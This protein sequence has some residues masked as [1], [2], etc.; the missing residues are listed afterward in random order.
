MTSGD[1]G[2]S[3]ASELCDQRDEQASLRRIANSMPKEKWYHYTDVHGLR[4]IIDRAELWGTHTAFLNDS[5]ELAYGVEVLAQLVNR[6]ASEMNLF[7]QGENGTRRMHPMVS[8]WQSMDASIKG[9]KDQLAYDLAPFVSCLSRSRDQLSQWRGYGRGG[10][11][12]IRFNS[13]KLCDSIR[14]VDSDR[15]DVVGGPK[16]VIERVA[17]VKQNFKDHIEIAV[18]KFLREIT[19]EDIDYEVAHAAFVD[20]VIDLASRMK[21]RAFQE[22]QETRIICRGRET[23]H[24][25]SSNLGLIPRVTLRFKRSAVR[26]VIVG[27]SEYADVRRLSVERYLK[28]HPSGKYAHV[29]VTSSAIPYRDI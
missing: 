5:Q 11:Y 4:G 8:L 2:P 14:Q 27:P 19:V 24:S 20:T 28:E 16:P 9:L 26:E 1:E 29:K 25:P 23:F 10:G 6:R 21:D 7:T 18:A 15:R 17:Y 13:N 3:E 22:E 12:A